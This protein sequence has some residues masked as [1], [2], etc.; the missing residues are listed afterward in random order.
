M[1]VSYFT[2]TFLLYN[3]SEDLE[4]EEE[5]SSSCT[6]YPDLSNS[7]DEIE[8][9]VKYLNRQSSLEDGKN[10]HFLPKISP[11]H[12][13]VRV[14]Q[15]N[16][17]KKHRIMRNLSNSGSRASLDNSSLSPSSINSHTSINS[18]NF[19]VEKGMY[20]EICIYMYIYCD[21]L[22]QICMW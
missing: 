11:S 8:D 13:R 17:K 19:F 1:Y 15:K 4:D 12:L 6:S 22:F 5:A 18:K 2:F 14:R 9:E 3:Y 10:D 21:Y 20:S 7:A 16:E